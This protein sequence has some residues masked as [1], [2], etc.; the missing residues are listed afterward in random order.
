MGDQARFFSGHLTEENQWIRTDTRNKLDF[1][2]KYILPCHPNT[3]SAVKFL[4]FE[5]EKQFPSKK[6]G[7]RDQW[8]EKKTPPWESASCS[9]QDLGDKSDIA[10]HKKYFDTVTMPESTDKTR[11]EYAAKRYH[12]IS[13]TTTMHR[14]FSV[15][16]V[17]GLIAGLIGYIVLK[18]KTYN[19]KQKIVK[20]GLTNKVDQLEPLAYAVV[21]PIHLWLPKFLHFEVGASFY[22]KALKQ[23]KDLKARYYQ[24]QADGCR[25]TDLHQKEEGVPPETAQEMLEKYTVPFVWGQDEMV[26][27]RGCR[28]PEQTMMLET[29]SRTLLL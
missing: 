5:Y 23:Y 4:Q 6:V 22:K 21:E 25:D 17:I 20:E 19:L 8:K 7:F 12:E 15:L 9:L 3:G 1:Y 26:P 16:A 13:L 14:L 10:Q 28:T 18:I 2:K 29:S 11:E 27:L 24:A